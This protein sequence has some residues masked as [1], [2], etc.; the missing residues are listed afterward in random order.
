MRVTTILDLAAAVLHNKQRNAN[1]IA[2]IF[3]KEG[4]QQ[5]AGFCA[6]NEP[7]A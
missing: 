5:A 2:I 6:H 1:D 4:N 7:E 3:S